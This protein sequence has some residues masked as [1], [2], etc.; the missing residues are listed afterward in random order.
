MTKKINLSNWSINLLKADNVQWF[1]WYVLGQ[2]EN[3][4]KSY[5]AVWECF[6]SCMD[7]RAKF[8][9][10]NS[11]YNLEV[12]EKKFKENWASEDELAAAVLSITEALNNFTTLELPTPLESEKEIIVELNDKYNLK[13]KFDA[14]YWDYILDHKTVSIFTKEEEADEKYWQQMKLYQYARYK[15]TWEKI[16]AYIQEIKKARASV[17]ATL[18]KA[19]LQALVPE[20]MKESTVN[21]M[22]D[23]LRAHPL[24]ERCWNRIEFKRNDS[25]IEEMESLLK[26]AMKKADYLQTLTLDD[27]L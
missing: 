15:Q 10:F 27:V 2:W 1:K 14:F 13:V 24:K 7:C 25:I 20:E 16:P 22:K 9:D 12:M 5:F 4:F 26:R 3:E 6:A 17:P 11:E 23:Y 19:D 21:D 18:L 8:G